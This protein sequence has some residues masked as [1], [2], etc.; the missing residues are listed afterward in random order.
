VATMVI[1]GAAVVVCDGVEG[2]VK[3]VFWG[4]SAQ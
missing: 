4:G 1:L 2:Y 3:T